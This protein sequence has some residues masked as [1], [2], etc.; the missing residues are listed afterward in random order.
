MP[1]LKPALQFIITS[2]FA[3]IAVLCLFV[4]VN[5]LHNGLSEISVTEIVQESVLLTIVVIHLWLA[6][7]N[8][9][10]RQC[11]ILIAGFFMT[12]LIRELDALFDLISHG[13]WVWFALTAALVAIISVAPQRANIIGQLTRYTQMNSWTMMMAGLIFVLVFS[14]LFGMSSLWHHILQGSYLRIVKN[15]VEEG[16]ELFGYLLCLMATLTY[17]TER[18]NNT[19]HSVR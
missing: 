1:L 10:L 14:R 11:N 13:S 17:I 5:V 8:A 9:E 7:K 2:V 6:R 18:N 19:A 3:L 4:D 12:M 16:S 15:M